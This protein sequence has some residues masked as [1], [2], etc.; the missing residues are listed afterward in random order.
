MEARYL[1][2]DLLIKSDSNLTALAE[3]FEDKAF[4]LWKELND[5]QSSLGLETNLVNTSS[6]EEDI[7]EFL[8]LIESMPPEL[9]SLWTNSKEKIM[10]IGYQFGTMTMPIDSFLSSKTVQRLAQLGCAINI[11]I[12]PETPIETVA[13]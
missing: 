10:D 12:Y 9:L 2:V 6:P 8:N 1:N 13:S 3:F 11:R 5:S 7:S 4:F